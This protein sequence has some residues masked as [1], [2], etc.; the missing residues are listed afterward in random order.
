MATPLESAD[1]HGHWICAVYLQVRAP[2]EPPKVDDGDVNGVREA[3]LQCA[4]KLV[5][6]IVFSH[7]LSVMPFPWLP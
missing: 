5:S 3:L 1:L 6:L 4:G 7:V 2:L